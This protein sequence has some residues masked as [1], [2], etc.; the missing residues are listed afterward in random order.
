MS[1]VFLSGSS[2]HDELL[3]FVETIGG[4]LINTLVKECPNEGWPRLCPG[5]FLI[6]L[7]VHPAHCPL[8]SLCRECF[9][10][11]SSNNRVIDVYQSFIFSGSLDFCRLVL[12]LK[13]E[14]RNMFDTSVF[15]A[16]WV[17]S[18]LDPFSNVF[19]LCL[20]FLSLL[21]CNK[22]LS[23]ILSCC[24]CHPHQIKLQVSVGFAN[25]VSPCSQCLYAC[26]CFYLLYY[27]LLCLSFAGRSLLIRVDL[28]VVFTFGHWSRLLMNLYKLILEFYPVS[29]H[30]SSLQGFISHDPFQCILKEARIRFL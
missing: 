16:S 26:H 14:A 2:Q 18:V 30:P 5:R 21:I 28:L 20:V 25:C 1:S 7:S 9:I 11:Q 13:T 4:D 22:I 8:A 27:S 3:S 10:Y 23:W 24:H 17:N 15:P 6:S 19:M 12:L 29:L